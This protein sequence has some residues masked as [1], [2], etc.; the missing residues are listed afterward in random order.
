MRILDSPKLA[1]LYIFPLYLFWSLPG[2]ETF[3]GST[4]TLGEGNSSSL[5]LCLLLGWE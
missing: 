3:L 4:W 5:P 1:F 2:F